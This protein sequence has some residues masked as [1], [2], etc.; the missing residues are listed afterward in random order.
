MDVETTKYLAVR[1]ELEIKALKKIEEIVEK[2][3]SLPNTVGERTEDIQRLIIVNDE[4]EDL[5]LNWSET[6][7]GVRSFGQGFGSDF[8]DLD[9]DLED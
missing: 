1:N 8:D 3:K 6:S 5:L 7:L 9:D 4:L 2:I